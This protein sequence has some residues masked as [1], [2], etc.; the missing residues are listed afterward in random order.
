MKIMKN[1]DFVF[2]MV[3]YTS[4]I[5]DRVHFYVVVSYP[6]NQFIDRQVQLLY[7]LIGLFDY[8]FV[9]Y[10]DSTQH[11]WHMDENEH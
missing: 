2:G 9:N 8:A 4:V 3:L 7:I 5:I 10:N 6:I 11:P 1:T